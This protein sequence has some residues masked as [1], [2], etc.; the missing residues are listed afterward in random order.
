MT[1]SISSLPSGFATTTRISE[2]WMSLSMGGPLGATGI[3]RI[4][5]PLPRPPLPLYWATSVATPL[6]LRVGAA[7][8]GNLAVGHT[9]LSPVDACDEPSGPTAGA[10]KAIELR[11]APSAATCVACPPWA[12]ITPASATEGDSATA[13][14][15]ASP[16]NPADADMAALLVEEDVQLVNIVHEQ[17]LASS[18]ELKL[19]LSWTLAVVISDV[20]FE[21]STQVKGKGGGGDSLAIKRNPTMIGNGRLPQHR[22][23]AARSG[24]LLIASSWISLIVIVSLYLALKPAAVERSDLIQE[25]ASM[26]SP[27]ARMTSLRQ[28]VC[29]DTPLSE[30]D[31]PNVGFRLLSPPS[32]H[33][34]LPYLPFSVSRRFVLS[35]WEPGGCISLHRPAINRCSRALQSPPFPPD[36]FA[37]DHLV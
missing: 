7:G 27:F 35:S 6:C 2:N 23:G 19:P 31:E 3:C 15:M 20:A 12:E 21:G 33:P 8:R 37:L 25:D 34:S 11:R 28:C 17:G 16:Q 18:P 9:D 14:R 13:R 22:H 5:L 24:A 29:P 36:F 32:T 26:M 1:P 10:I 4:P 30:I